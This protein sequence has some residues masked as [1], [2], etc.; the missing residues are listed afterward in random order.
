MGA[1]EEK[2]PGNGST[3]IPANAATPQSR[4]SKSALTEEQTKKLNGQRALH[5]KASH[6]LLTVFFL[7]ML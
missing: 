2:L 5:F 6:I 3:T 1:E 4:T 7:W